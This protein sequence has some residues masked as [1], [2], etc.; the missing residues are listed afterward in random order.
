VDRG[1]VGLNTTL[2]S[3]AVSVRHCMLNEVELEE[4]RIALAECEQQQMAANENVR[5]AGGARSLSFLAAP[6]ERNRGNPMRKSAS[7]LSA[8]HFEEPS[9]LEHY[10][11]IDIRQSSF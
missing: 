1:L 9:P 8:A 2:I 6:A 7:S 11:V 10:G 3:A 4:L 5:T